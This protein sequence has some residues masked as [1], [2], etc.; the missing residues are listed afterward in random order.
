MTAESSYTLAAAERGESTAYRTVFGSGR[1]PHHGTSIAQ[2]KS[3]NG[4][5]AYETLSGWFSARVR[6]A[7]R[8]RSRARRLGQRDECRLRDVVRAR[9][10]RSRTGDAAGADAAVHLLVVPA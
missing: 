2:E 3:T 9:R 7:R 8:S 1:K 4:G 5:P 10:G 6:R